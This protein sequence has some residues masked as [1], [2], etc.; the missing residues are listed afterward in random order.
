MWFCVTSNIRVGQ[1]CPVTGS[2]RI[3][4]L[5]HS[6]VIR[7]E[8]IGGSALTISSSSTLSVRSAALSHLQFL[9]FRATS[10]LFSFFPLSSS[11]ALTPS[12]SHH[13]TIPENN[14][15]LISHFNKHHGVRITSPDAT[16]QRQW[17]GPAQEG[18]RQFPARFRGNQ[19]T[20]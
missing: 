6:G 4:T 12:Y 2:L 18:S 11:R 1:V 3:P 14:S 13:N 19:K 20:T 10:S 7:C 9:S 8:Q 16:D 15:Q 17:Q 5:T